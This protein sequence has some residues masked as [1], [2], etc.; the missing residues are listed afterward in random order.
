MIFSERIP[1]ETLTSVNSTNVA[2]W[3]E[4]IDKHQL[5]IWGHLT[6]PHSQELVWQVLTDYE[7][8]P[9][10]IPDLIK[11]QRIPHP[12]S[13]VR[14][15]QVGAKTLLKFQF[16]VRAVLDL[17]EQFPHQIQFQLVEG[18]FQAL[19]GECRLQ[20][21]YCLDRTFTH[22]YY[23]VKLIPKLSIPT[24]FLEK[25]IKTYLPLNLLAIH[26][27]VSYT[28]LNSVLLSQ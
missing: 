9:D 7:A 10:F 23:S 15:E 27:R 8:L 14:L 22:L 19:S 24:V 18:D 25:L 11:S 16:S 5:R 20:E 3:I 28:S 1:P 17:V 4:K 2:V 12:A 6:V 13:G 21:E 26:Q